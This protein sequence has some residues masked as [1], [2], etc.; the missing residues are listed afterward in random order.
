MVQGTQAAA[1]EG[2]GDGRHEVATTVSSVRPPVLS[3]GL[4]LC[5]T[6]DVPSPLLLP[7]V[8]LPFLGYASSMGRA[9]QKAPR[10]VML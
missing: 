5:L 1:R 4:F 9:R 8:L 10:L 3:P 2:Q 6:P 7:I